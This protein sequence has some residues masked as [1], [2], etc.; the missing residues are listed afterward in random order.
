MNTTNKSRYIRKSVKNEVDQ[1]TNFKCAWCGVNLMERHHI[2]EYAVGG[3]NEADNLILLC[4][5][6]HTDVHKGKIEDCELRS[7][8]KLLSGEI[9]RNSGNIT[10]T[11]KS[12]I[13]IGGNTF[14]NTPDIIRHNGEVVLRIIPKN[15]NML[16]SLKLYNQKRELICWMNE[17]RWWVENEAVFDTIQSKSLFTL[18]YTETIFFSIQADEKNDC[19]E[20]SGRIYLNG[21]LLQFDKDN[22][23]YLN[24]DNQNIATFRG[25]T[26]E[27]CGCA[28]NLETNN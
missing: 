22:I 6:C 5:N 25:C 12:K 2:T 19:I 7:R 20:L 13:L 18:K 10:F 9:N 8:K 14:I 23:T 1:E 16:V 17:N 3:S 28:V 15:K 11:E 4:P 24:P 27:N 26:I 21:Y